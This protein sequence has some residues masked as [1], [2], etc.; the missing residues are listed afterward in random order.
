MAIFGVGGVVVKLDSKAPWNKLKEIGIDDLESSNFEENFHADIDGYTIRERAVA[1][2]ISSEQ[3]IGAI[4]KLSRRDISVEKIRDVIN[5]AITDVNYDVVEILQ[6]LR[7]KASN[8][9]V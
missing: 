8:S 9:R 3:Y 6:D 4:Q 1:G 7:K 5:L 2:L